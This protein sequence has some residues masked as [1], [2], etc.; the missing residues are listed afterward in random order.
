MLP[1][2]ASTI[3][4]VQIINMPKKTMRLMNSNVLIIQNVMKATGLTQIMKLVLESGVMISVD[5]LK[6]VVIV[7][8]FVL[9]TTVFNVI[10]W[11]LQML[12]YV[13]NVKMD[14]GITKEFAMHV[15]KIVDG[16]I[17]LR[18]VKFVMLTD[19]WTS[20]LTI[21]Q[22]IVPPIKS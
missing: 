10:T 1:V 3:L 11:F 14:T 17:T 13:I 18:L 22:L 5:Y 20:Q 7:L 12:K 16:V 8:L 15:L 2:F 9:Q 6:L 4:N 21:V 19:I